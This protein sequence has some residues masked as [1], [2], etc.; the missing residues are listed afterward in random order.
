M[1]RLSVGVS[2]WGFRIF[3]PGRV[4]IRQLPPKGEAGEEEV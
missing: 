1:I 3:D 2:G 4:N